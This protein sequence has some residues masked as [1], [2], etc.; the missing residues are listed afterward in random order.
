[1]AARVSSSRIIGRADAL[2]R[3]ES[4]VEAA[5][6]GRP[7]LT[8]VAGVAGVG[9]TRLV[10][11]LMRRARERD[12]FVLNGNCIDLGHDRELPFLPLVAALRP[13]ARTPEAALPE[14]L[15]D[16]VGPL[17]P[18]V[19]AATP[20]ADDG[21]QVR[22]FEGLLSLLDALAQERPVLLAI[23]DLHWADRSTRVALTFLA[24]SVTTERLMLLATY[25]SDELLGNDPLRRLLAGLELDQRA[26][27]ISLAP[28]SRGELAEQLTDIL[29]A[30]P[31]PDLLE[32]LWQRS[33]GNPLFGEELVVAGHDGRGALPDTLR[34]ALMLRVERLP[35]AALGI[36]A[37]VA[38]GERVDHA[39]LEDA[40]GLDAQAFNE[41][42]RAAIDSHVL[43]PGADDSYQFR[44]ALLREVVEGELLPGERARL[45]LTLA[46]MLQRRT[47]FGA[48]PRTTAAVAHHF[49]AGR[50]HTAALAAAVEAATA[51]ERVY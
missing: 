20:A 32:R 17:M 33:G 15:R 16:A 38:V 30:P 29:G 34:D 25:R 1:M 40:S 11:E 36:L 51:A 26:R 4:A 39:L 27:R 12:V 43:V 10:E 48:D 44:H 6:D 31:S 21:G 22:L 5:R 9:K 28:L 3:L 23:E 47:E 35:E 50:D 18:G 45:H 19:D 41:A 8:F 49:L 37:L 42:L 14:T 24:R 13:L 2:A 7:A 46:R